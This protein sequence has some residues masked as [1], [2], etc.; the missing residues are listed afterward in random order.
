MISAMGGLTSSER[1]FLKWVTTSS[2]VAGSLAE[3]AA[4]IRGSCPRSSPCVAILLCGGEAVAL[5]TV[6]VGV[7]I[8]KHMVKLTSVFFFV[9]QVFQFMGVTL[10]YR[11]P[12][13]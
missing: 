8:L 10:T 12:R 6:Q 7:C 5:V 11:T 1:S 2:S 3:S 4:T 13:Q 9:E